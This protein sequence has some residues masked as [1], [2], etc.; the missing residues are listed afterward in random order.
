MLT[1]QAVDAYPAR[2]WRK[3]KR[4][5]RWWCRRRLRVERERERERE[6][7]GTAHSAVEPSNPVQQTSSNLVGQPVQTV[8]SNP[9][10]QPQ[11]PPIAPATDAT[12]ELPTSSHHVKGSEFNSSY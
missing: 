3:R 6:R 5:R 12:V 11:H 4:K 1:Q 9:V 7:A 10:Q 8:H 2:S